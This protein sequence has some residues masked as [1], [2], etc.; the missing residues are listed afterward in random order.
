MYK[1]ILIFYCLWSVSLQAQT[2]SILLKEIVLVATQT[3]KDAFELPNAITKIDSKNFL[4]RQART[5]PEILLN[6]GIWTQKT[7]HGGGSL[8]MR[9]LTGNQILLLI[10]GIRLN[11]STY[12]Y[13]PN[14]YLN[15]IDA[16]SI[17]SLELMQGGG[18]VLY[19]SDALGGTL[20]MLTRP[21]DFSDTKKVNVTWIGR[22]ATQNI[23]KST[24]ADFQ[25][26]QKKWAISSGLTYRNFGDLV[27]GDTTGIQTPSGYKELAYDIKA[28]FSI[29]KN[30]TLTALHQLVRQEDVAV[31]HK[32]RLENFS[33]NQMQP[34][35]RHLSYL[36][37]D[38]ALRSKLI[39]RL[40]A[41]VSIQ[42][43]LETRQSQKNGSTKQSNET[44][45]I[46]VLGAHL[47]AES[48]VKPF[49][50]INTGTEIYLDKVNSEKVEINK[51]DNSE[52]SKR[53]LYPDAA[54]YTNFAVYQS[55]YLNWKKWALQAGLR[56]NIYQINIDDKD[57]GTVKIQPSALVYDAAIQYFI[58]KK[59]QVYL[60]FLTGF[61]APNIDDMGTLGIVD[62]RYE[63]PNYNL[64]PE[65]SRNFE[66]G[67]KLNANR[68][69][70]NTYFYYNHLENL[71]TRTK[72]NQ[73]INTYQV[74]TKENT[75][76][77]FIKGFEANTNIL[78]TSNLIFKSAINYTFGQNL[79]KNEPLR[80]IPPLHYN[81]Q[82]QYSYKKFYTN[83]T[84]F[85]A[86]KQTRLAQG[87]KDDNRI[88]KGGTGAFQVLSW[89]GGYTW[90]GFDA[91]ISVQNLT[92]ADYRIHGSGLNGAGRHITFSLKYTF[93]ND[94]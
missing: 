39:N 72:Q 81:L 40:E 3:N 64:A 54:T 59:Q 50:R 70:F 33:L 30:I 55:H 23:E 28:K 29:C 51:T 8:F 58:Q 87:D 84:Y 62:F 22:I 75:D 32:V 31:F 71:I 48:V 74:Y 38:Y 14:Q 27:G 46:R 4:Q 17:G 63:L 92:N 86:N 44:D 13:G 67:Y 65:K 53:G 1:K 5:S 90:R 20:Q 85:A 18:S 7:N 36:K 11:N 57:L 66:V 21:L 2:D 9:G 16:F 15:T 19:G 89:F 83:F 34:Q 80:R 79:S 93:Q 26:S 69:K 82:L 52:V 91:N 60:H 76:Q 25:L 37:L 94:K 45:K 41:N 68:F 49:Y 61:R 6:E 78:I 35:Q 73:V 10:D 24:H 88:P 43:T 12:R 47:F 42:N 77:A 56:Y